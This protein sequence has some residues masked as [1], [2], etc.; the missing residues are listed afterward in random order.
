M[1]LHFVLKLVAAASL[2]GLRV[3]WILA[4]QRAYANLPPTTTRRNRFI[5]MLRMIEVLF[6]ILIAIYLFGAPILT[7]TPSVVSYL[8][9]FAMLYCGIW[10]AV[11]GRRALGDNWTHM[12]DYQVKSKQELVTHGIF[13]YI[14][15][16]MYTGFIAIFTGMFIVF[17]SWLWI[18]ILLV[19]TAYIYSQA[20]KEEYLLARHFGKTYLRYLHTSKMF[21]PYLW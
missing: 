13:Q 3:Y 18:P 15:H 21:I 1:T 10:V 16:P 14:R 7:F 17:A 11:S 8:F 6:Y 2:I 12:I 19:T 20:K 5:H 4:E 9:G